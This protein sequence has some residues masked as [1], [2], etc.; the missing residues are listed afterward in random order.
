MGGEGSGRKPDVTKKILSDFAKNQDYA[1]PIASAIVLPNFSGIRD[2]A[3]KDKPAGAS[4]G[5]TWGTITGTLSDQT[6]LQ[7]ALNTKANISGQV[8][9]GAISATNLSGTNTGNQTIALTGDVTGSGTGT[10]ATTIANDAVSYAKMQNVSATNV[11]MGRKTAGSGDMEEIT[12]TGDI[13]QSGSTITIP[14]DTVTY[15]KM[16]NITGSRLVGRY[17]SSSGDMEEIQIGTG[18][19]FSGNTLNSSNQA[20][21]AAW[22]SISGTLSSQ[23]DLQTALNAKLSLTGGTMTGQ[24]ILAAGTTASNTAPLK[25]TTGTSQTSAQAGAMEFTTDDLFFT[26]TTGTARKRFVLADPVGGLSSGRMPYATTNGRLNDSA[27]LLWD[28]T[29]Y[30]LIGLA[31]AANVTPI[32]LRGASSQTADLQKWQNS[33]STDLARID[34]AGTG[35]FSGTG[36]STLTQ[37]LVIASAAG[38]ADADFLKLNMSGAV[39]NGSVSGTATFKQ[40]DA[41]TAFKRVVIYCNALNGTASY[42]Y[43]TAFTNTPDVISQN[44]TGIATTVSNTAITLTGAVSSGHVLLEG[45]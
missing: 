40:T 31:S 21:T 7:T 28:G 29:N 19:A 25:F 43:T 3:R 45:Y 34:S 18:L 12:L 26:I 37:G 15:A 14:N 5:G 44:L 24:E 30:T 27:N 4:G 6:D 2:E 10:F 33:S 1:L 9:T 23:T 39:V 8:F 32:I 20:G 38:T 11:V 42:T 13:T 41:G 16:Q 35:Y 17:D 36:A 22:G